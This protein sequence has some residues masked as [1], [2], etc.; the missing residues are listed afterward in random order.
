MSNDKAVSHEEAREALVF[1]SSC[2]GSAEPIIERYIDQSEARD[3]DFYC[4]R[5]PSDVLPEFG[6]IVEFFTKRR[7]TLSVGWR[8]SEFV[9]MWIDGSDDDGNGQDAQVREEDIYC[10]RPAPRKPEL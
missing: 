9:G 6:E 10:W 7:D 3:N 1:L 2:D 5:R 4:W 8:S